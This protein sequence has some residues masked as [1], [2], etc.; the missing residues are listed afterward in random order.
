MAVG[1]VKMHTVTGQTTKNESLLSDK[2][3]GVVRCLVLEIPVGRPQS[4]L[5]LVSTSAYRYED[6]SSRVVVLPE[7][8]DEDEDDSIDVTG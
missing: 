5:V 8:D 4:C 6:S 7:D 1:G 3:C 2:I